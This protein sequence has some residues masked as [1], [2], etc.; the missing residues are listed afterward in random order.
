MSLLTI[1]MV[2]YHLFVPNGTTNDLL[3]WLL[4]TVKSWFVKKPAPATILS[5]APVLTLKASNIDGYN[6]TIVPIATGHLTSALSP[7]EPPAERK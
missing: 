6:A 7:L 3:Q 4:A 5:A 2:A 1:V